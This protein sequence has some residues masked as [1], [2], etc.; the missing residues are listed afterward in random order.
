MRVRV[1]R[2]L[3]L[4]HKELAVIV[5]AAVL[6]TTISTVSVQRERLYEGLMAVDLS[7]VLRLRNHETDQVYPT[8]AIA[9]TPN[10]SPNRGAEVVML[11]AA[12]GSDYPLSDIRVLCR[13]GVPSPLEP[14]A[15][16]FAQ[17]IREHCEFHLPPS[18]GQEL[19]RTSTQMAPDELNRRRFYLNSLPFGGLLIRCQDLIP[20]R[21]TTETR[22]F[23]QWTK[24]NCTFVPSWVP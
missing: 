2:R 23:S 13:A 19:V 4:L 5:V 11:P 22:A 24:A 9:R 3:S 18:A 16:R 6:V 21:F 1:P 8:L 17:G 10:G 12:G 15:R 7:A 20:L 14:S